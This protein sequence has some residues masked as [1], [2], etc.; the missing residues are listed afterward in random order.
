MVRLTCDEK[1]GYLHDMLSLNIIEA[2]SEFKELKGKN[3]TEQTQFWKTHPE[4]KD[5]LNMVYH[6][7]SKP[8]TDI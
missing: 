5:F 6:N 4:A 2:S 3:A 1:Y 8:I 7:L